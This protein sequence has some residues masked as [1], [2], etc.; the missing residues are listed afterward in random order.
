MA[1]AGILSTQLVVG[2]FIRDFRTSPPLTASD[3]VKVCYGSGVAT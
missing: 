2:Q 1:L 3:D